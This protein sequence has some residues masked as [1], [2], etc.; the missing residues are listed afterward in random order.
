VIQAPML[1]KMTRQE[2]EIIHTGKY[3]R[4]C[5]RTE[6]LGGLLSDKASIVCPLYLS[7]GGRSSISTRFVATV[8][9]SLV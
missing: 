7:H 1:G 8:W 3:R 9:G 6:T 2:T 4:G 5:Y